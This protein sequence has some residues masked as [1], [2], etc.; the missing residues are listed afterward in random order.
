[1]RETALPA[2]WRNWEK[3]AERTGTYQRLR[4]ITPAMVLMAL[5]GPGSLPYGKLP[6]IPLLGLAVGNLNLEDY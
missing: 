6:S 3:M 5:S 4:V 1:M 2:V